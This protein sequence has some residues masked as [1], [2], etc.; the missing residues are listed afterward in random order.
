MG[1]Q[2]PQIPKHIAGHDYASELNENIQGRI[3]AKAILGGIAGTRAL[4]KA[5]DYHNS[6]QDYGL[7]SIF[8]GILKIV[9]K[10]I[11]KIPKQIPKQIP[12]ALIEGAVN[13]AASQGI[14]H[15][16]GQDYRRGSGRRNSRGN[17]RGKPR[18]GKPRSEKPR[19]TAHA[20]ANAAKTFTKEIGIGAANELGVQAVR[21][22]FG[23]QGQQQEPQY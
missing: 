9:P 21:N 3:A 7:G 8:R 12:E 23:S 18:S 15:A 14:K 4:N 20:I 17:S 10:I 5:Q 6:V 19:R 13:E 1:F 2:K 16:F 22:A 11:P